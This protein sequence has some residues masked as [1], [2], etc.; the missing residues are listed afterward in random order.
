MD[1]SI[2]ACILAL[3]LVG[4]SSSPGDSAGDAC[5][6]EPVGQVVFP[7]DEAIHDELLEWW[8]W[9]GHLQDEQG[10]WYGFEQTFFVFQMGVFDAT[11][12]HVA[13]TDIEAQRFSF[14]HVLLEELPDPEMQGIDLA[15]EHN[16]AQGVGGQDSLHGETDGYV[17]DLVLS[18]DKPTV[19][20]HGD[21]YHDYDVGGYTWYYSRERMTV[22]GSL[23]VDGEPRVVTGQ[24]WM[25]H[26]WGNLLLIAETGWEWFAIQL[27]DGREI[28][29]FL[30]KGGEEVVGGSISGA[31]CVTEELTAEEILVTATGEWTSPH[32]G[33]SYPSG[34]QLQLRDMA[35][36]VTPVMEDQE[37]Y[38]DHE[39]YWEGASTV[40][41]DVTG[42]AYVEL[43]GYCDAE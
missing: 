2:T 9:T 39:T 16:T 12:A 43:A 10:R 24:G 17:L 14:D 28:M 11:M 5:D 18:Q 27:D 21:G 38:S 6:E 25:D 42:R 36:T 3:L 41:G 30:V 1:R 23:E 4:C 40:S 32:T 29:L 31:D 26:Q 22:S 19:L 20:Q 33:C 34:W 7:D 35:L 8:Y 37:L 13:V 15:A